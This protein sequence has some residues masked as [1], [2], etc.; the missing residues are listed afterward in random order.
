MLTY[1]II[2]TILIALQLLYAI[3]MLIEHE[4]LCFIFDMLIKF[5]IKLHVQATTIL[6]ATL[7]ATI[8]VKLIDY[9]RCVTTVNSF[10]KNQ[11]KD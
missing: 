1:T 8:F 5:N 7:T 4:V 6:Y 2:K 9:I 11:K 3:L 10:F